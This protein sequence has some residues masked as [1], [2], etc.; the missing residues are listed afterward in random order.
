M[1]QFS[2]LPSLAGYYVFNIVGSPIR[3]SMDHRSF[4]SPH[5]FSQLTTSFIVSTSL[6]IPRTPFF[7]SFFLL[8]LSF[9][10]PSLPLFSRYPFI[11]PVLSMNFFSLQPQPPDFNPSTRNL[12]YFYFP[13][14]PPVHFWPLTFYFFLILWRIRESNPWPLEC[15]SSALASWANPPLFISSSLYLRSPYSLCEAFTSLLFCSLGRIWT[16]DPYII[17]VVL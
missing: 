8:S 10:S 5:S 2:G 1:F 17:S 12:N 11:T 16:A 14:Q 4:A 9:S 13:Y 15:K 7:A 6:G 3:T